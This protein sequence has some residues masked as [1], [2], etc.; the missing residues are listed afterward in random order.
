M[1]HPRSAND[2]SS[3]ISIP[4]LESDI[5][6]SQFEV[7]PSN[8]ANPYTNPLSSQMDNVKYELYD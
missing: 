4:D 8:V 5:L 2:N 1:D 7:P 3:D 6:G